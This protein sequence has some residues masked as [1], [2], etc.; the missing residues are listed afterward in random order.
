MIRKGQV[1][2]VGKGDILNQEVALVS[3]MFGVA[4]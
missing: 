3:R 4:A 1:K 2:N